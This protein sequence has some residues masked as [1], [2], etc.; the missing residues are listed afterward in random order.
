MFPPAVWVSRLS[1]HMRLLSLM[2]AGSVFSF[3]AFSEHLTRDRFGTKPGAKHPEAGNL[4][5]DSTQDWN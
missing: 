3:L 4:P 1:E 5:I 2:D